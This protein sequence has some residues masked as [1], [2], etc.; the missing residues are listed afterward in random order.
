M[1][2]FLEDSGR[3]DKD[4]L[5]QVIEAVIK[6][7]ATVINIPDTTGYTTP[8]EYGALIGYVMKHVPN[9]DRAIVSVHCHNDLG[10]ATANALA[11]VRN[12]ARQIECTINGIGERAGNTSLEEV[13]MAMKVRRDM[14]RL[15][16]G[17]QSRRN[18]TRRAAWSARRRAFWCSRTRPS[19]A[20]TRSRIPAAS[21]RTAF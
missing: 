16:N 13:V 9:I 17:H 15:R 4:Y 6:A 7:G 18:C 14:L 12:G 2:Y 20:Q 10:M 5:C 1:E 21:I 8:D 3:A 19:S 11:G